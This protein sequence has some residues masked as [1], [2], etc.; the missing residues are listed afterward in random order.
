VGQQALLEADDEDD[1]VLEALGGVQGDEGDA[2]ALIAQL[3]DVRHEGDLLQERG[4]G[5]A[6]GQGGVAG[7]YRVQLAQVLPA[8]VG[9]GEV[10]LEVVA[11]ADAH[12]DEVEQIVRRVGLHFDGELGHE[13]AEGDQGVARPS[14][15]REA[16][17]FF[18]HHGDL[19]RGEALLARIASQLGCGA[20]AEAS[21]WHV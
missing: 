3:V 20:L 5:L 1:G 15:D 19:E 18:G 21:G 8:V 6:R 2:L 17:L 13:A 12:Q 9:V 7:S 14:G 10:V 16:L 4:E 11:V